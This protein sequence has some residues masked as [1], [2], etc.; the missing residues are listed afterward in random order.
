M[1]NLTAIGAANLSILSLLGGVLALMIIREVF[2]FISQRKPKSENGKSDAAGAR[3][4]EFWQAQQRT[5]VKEVITDLLSPFLATQTELLRDIRE[6]TSN[7]RD[8]VLE[9]VSADRKRAK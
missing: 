1:E 9:L 5:A 6:A 3:S 8:G 4:V 7:T 2:K